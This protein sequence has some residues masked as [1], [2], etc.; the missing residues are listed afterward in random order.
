M[1]GHGTFKLMD[2]AA[3]N[4]ILDKKT[5]LVGLVGVLIG[6]GLGFIIGQNFGASKGPKEVA[7]QQSQVTADKAI[8]NQ[9]ATATGK[10]VAVSSTKLTI[11]GTDGQQ[12]EFAVSPTVNVYVYKDKN[13]PAS[14]A[15]DIKAVDLNRDVLLKMGLENNQYVVA[16]ITVLPPAQSLAS[17]TA[18]KSP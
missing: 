13:S 14:V 4:D 18:S 6:L 17:P 3:A 7:T 16:T 11:V 1:V 9:G 10:V 15:N 12:S 2:P 8:F 5:A